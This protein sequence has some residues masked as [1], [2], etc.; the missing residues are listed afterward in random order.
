MNL[1]HALNRISF[2][3][4]VNQLKHLEEVGWEAFVTEQLKPIQEKNLENRISGLTYEVEYESRGRDK[5]KVM[6]FGR[7]NMNGEELWQTVAHLDD[8][9]DYLLR[10]P[11]LETAFY[12]YMNALHSENQLFEVM[13]EFWHN[14]FN[15]SVEAEDQI[16]LLLPTYD[17]DVIRKNAFGNFR[18]FLEDVAK[19]PCMLYYLDNAYSVASPA[20]E[21]YARELFELHTLG[22]MHYYN[23]LYDDWRHVPT[24]EN[25]TAL[26]YI[27][28]DV[29]EVA[30]AFTGWTVADGREFH[31]GKFES[32]GKFHY[33]D[34]WHDH[35]QK[36][37]LGVEFKSHQD[38]MEDGLKVLDMLAQH[39]GTAKYVC[40][41]LC[42]WLVSENPSEDLIHRAI[43]TWMDH[44]QDEDQIAKVIRVILMSPDFKNNLNEKVKRPNHLVYSIARQLELDIAPSPEWIWF[45]RDLGYRQFTWPTPTGHP[46]NSE[47]WTSSDM[48]LK[49]WNAPLSIL[50]YN[51]ENLEAGSVLTEMVTESTELHLDAIIDFWSTKLLGSKIEGEER[52]LMKKA[53]HQDMEDLKEDQ[54]GF[55]L[56]HY[57]EAFEFKQMQIMG[58]LALSP[59]F[60]KR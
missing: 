49:R 4:D 28:E 12:T 43:E 50:Y 38:A 16:A 52:A 55:L 1:R 40:T 60:Q 2:G 18:T 53:V 47:Y 21:N 26:G 25:G 5:T 23:D 45:L 19:S 13:V 51:Y 27:D 31:G 8:P 20:N 44:W 10:A 17:R 29:Y 37:I 24:D 56:E 48:L 35:Y 14:H 39:K 11:A 41:K 57:P 3:I 59:E 46:D 58:L 9:D 34:Q 42:S 7:Y 36:R 32:T 22:A 33:Y 6:E 15:I 54:W 30:R